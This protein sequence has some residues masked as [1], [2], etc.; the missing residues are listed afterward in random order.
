[1]TLTY[2]QAC[3]DPNLFDP[4]FSGPT[5]SY[6]RVVDKVIFG[7]PLDDAELAIFKQLSGLRQAP[8]EPYREVWLCFGRR[9][10]KDLKAASIN[11]YLATIGAE[12]FGYLDRLVRGE[13]GVVQLLAVDRDQAA[14]CLNFTRAFF[15]QPMLAALVKRQTTDTIELHSGISIEITTNDRRRVRGRTVISCTLDEV[16]HWRSVDSSVNPD[17]DVYQSVKPSMATIP[18]ALMLGI[19]SPYSRRG[20]F[21]RKYREAYGKRGQ[22]LFLKAPTWQMNPNL[23]RRGE[24]ILQAYE[25]DASWASAE[26]G[27]EFRTDL[28]AFVSADVVEACTVPGRHELPRLADVSYKAFC[29]P[30]GGSSDSMTLTIAH[31]EGDRVILDCVRERRAP[32]NPDDVTREFSETLKSFG[33]CRVRGDRY[34]G[35]WPKARFEAHGIS[36]EAEERPKSVLYGMLLPALN[37]GKVELLDLPKMA[38]QLVGLERRTSRGGKDSIDHAPGAHD[39]IAN[40]VAGVVARLL[41]RGKLITIDADDLAFEPLAACSEGSPFNMFSTGPCAR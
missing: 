9:S 35:E 27:A 15:E 12:R 17:E 31:R 28:E 20:L 8:T 38:A 34:A 11:V 39:D 40:A 18:N 19:S 1:M 4:W 30:S 33:L 16:A 36:Y 29:D 13:R 25:S 21:W 26:Y 22:V 37:S 41:L 14:V 5:W 24:V 7:E 6:W 10:A 32:F 2:S 23:P 3:A